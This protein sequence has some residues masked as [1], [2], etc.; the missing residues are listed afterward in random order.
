METNFDPQAQRPPRSRHLNFIRGRGRGRGGYFSRQPRD[1]YIKTEEVVVKDKKTGEEKEVKVAEVVDEKKLAA[2]RRK[3]AKKRAKK[4]NKEPP[5]RTTL[6]PVW[7]PEN[8]YG[9]DNQT[10]DTTISITASLD[11][12]ALTNIA[13]TIVSTGL[14]LGGDGNSSLN[15]QYVARFIAQYIFDEAM[16]NVHQYPLEYMPAVL[17]DILHAVSPRSKGNYSYNTTRGSFSWSET[18]A[19]FVGRTFGIIV[20]TLTSGFF[21]VNYSMAGYTAEL[22]IQHTRT[23]FK[24]MGEKLDC[25]EV[26]YGEIKRDDGSA[27]SFANTAP[28]N[29]PHFGNYVYY[30]GDGTQSFGY[31]EYNFIRMTKSKCHWLTRLGLLLADTQAI[32]DCILKRYMHPGAIVAHRI[33]KKL[34][35]YK[36]H[37]VQP[38]VKIFDMNTM[39]N[40][41]EQIFNRCVAFAA[42]NPF[43]TA[44]TYMTFTDFKWL[45]NI[46]LSRHLARYASVCVSLGVKQAGVVNPCDCAATGNATL[47]TSASIRIP[48]VVEENISALYDYAHGDIHVYPAA[49]WQGNCVSNYPS[50]WTSEGIGGWFSSAWNSFNNEIGV[51]SNEAAG[52]WNSGFSVILHTWN[53]CMNVLQAYVPLSAI[54]WTSNFCATQSTVI[55]DI[56]NENANVGTCTIRK[57]GAIVQEHLDLMLLPQIFIETDGSPGLVENWRNAVQG[58]LHEPF[59]NPAQFGQIGQVFSDAVMITVHALGGAGDQDAEVEKE[60]FSY[61]GGNLKDALKRAVG[62]Q[63]GANNNKNEEGFITKENVELAAKIGSTLL[64]LAK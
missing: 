35:G 36:D 17:W 51:S 47:R 22:G 56:G 13:L 34:R 10:G 53:K 37:T 26:G 25:V 30:E 48:Q 4:R 59:Y 38:I 20:E 32:G 64:A 55:I 15:H 60:E 14:A 61:P 42:A 58:V 50:M 28:D 41:M 49:F 31:T 12:Q 23:F 27:W 1:Q 16:G 7:G 11:N 18:R 62:G 29:K 54:C 46:A 21:T 24:D 33:L 43:T 19:K 3:N 63:R 6:L 5:V 52:K 40:S 8:A 9:K 45:M 2:N 39:I 57:V 44:G